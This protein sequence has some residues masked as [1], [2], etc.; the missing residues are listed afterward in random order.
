MRRRIL[1]ACG[2]R[3]RRRADLGRGAGCRGPACRGRGI[4]GRQPHFALARLAPRADGARGAHRKDRRQNACRRIPPGSAPRRR[5][6]GSAYLGNRP[7]LGSRAARVFARGGPARARAPA[8]RARAPRSGFA[9]CEALDRTAPEVLGPA[10]ARR[11]DAPRSGARSPPHYRGA[12]R[13]DGR[14]LSRGSGRSRRAPRRGGSMKMLAAVVLVCSACARLG[15][16]DTA[17]D[18]SL[19]D[20][21]QVLEVEPPEGVADAKAVFHVSFSAAIDQGQLIAS[22][23][24]SESVALVAESVVDRAAAA[25]EH[26]RLTVEERGL[27]VAAAAGIEGEGTGL[28]LT[29]EA[30]LAPGTY[31]LLIA[32]RLH[33]P[34]G[35]RLAEASRYRYTVA[36]PKG[37]VEL[38]SPVPGANAAANLARV[39]VSVASGSG[40]LSL[41]GP[42][43]VVAKAPIGA[44]GPLELPL[45]PRST[46]T[47]APLQ[48]GQTYT[49]ALDGRAIDGTSFSVARCSRLW[50]PQGAARFAVRDTSVLADVQLDWPARIVLRAGCGEGKCPEA[51]AHAICA[52]DPCATT[53][54]GVCTASLRLDGLAAAT[55]YFLHL[56]LEDD[57]GHATVA[58]LQRVAKLSPLPTV[59]I[60]E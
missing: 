55:G 16:A 39:W 38:L 32:A 10:E 26:S 3:A 43:G 1:D 25:I 51:S 36:A 14:S 24:R 21:P 53:P 45:C 60:S 47:C 40:T 15:G 37:R 9:G 20:L 31:Y 2:C 44:P 54:V 19:V 49:L 7:H 6:R 30:P 57:D 12:R 23:G 52:P 33:D 27:L 34:A 56:D 8:P 48:A 58:G 42:G 13:P 35:H 41:V 5:R 17:A 29:P 4:G 18:G 11:A 28:T 46:K 22:T 50:P 59:A